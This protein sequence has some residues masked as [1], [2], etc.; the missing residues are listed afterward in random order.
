MLAMNKNL[1]INGQVELYCLFLI[2]KVYMP[3]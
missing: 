3:L 2:A 1:L